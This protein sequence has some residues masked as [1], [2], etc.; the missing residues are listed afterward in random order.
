MPDVC[1]EMHATSSGSS[2]NGGHQR[3]DWLACI[4]TAKLKLI[5]IS[6]TRWRTTWNAIRRA[7]A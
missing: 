5:A 4:G 2:V 6:P 7:I 3:H 1:D